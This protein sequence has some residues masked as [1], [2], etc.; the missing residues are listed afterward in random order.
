MI[1]F[2]KQGEGAGGGESSEPVH[3]EQSQHL[4]ALSPAGEGASRQDPTVVSASPPS[5]PDAPCSAKLR[6]RALGSPH[7]FSI[8]CRSQ[9]MQGRL[10]SPCPAACLVQIFVSALSI[11]RCLH[12]GKAELPTGSQQQ[13]ETSQNIPRVRSCGLSPTLINPFITPPAPHCLHPSNSL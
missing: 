12:P 4:S 8:P 1:Y 11:L 6:S 10:F 3:R 5:E 7:A 9:P 2:C 13:A